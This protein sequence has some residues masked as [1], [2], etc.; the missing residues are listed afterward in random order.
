ML[1]RIADLINRAPWRVSIAAVLFAAVAGA[2]GG[3]VAATLK[4]GGFVDPSSE[5]SRAAAQIERATGLRADGGL[6]AVVDTGQPV[7]SA[8]TRAEVERVAGVIGRERAVSR[9]LTYYGSG[10][11]A[12]VSANGRETLVAGLF[13]SQSDEDATAAAK[14]VQAALAPDGQVRVGGFAVANAQ[15][16]D[17]VTQDLARAEVLAFPIL[18]LLSLWVFRGAVAALLP[19]MVGGTTIV[20]AFLGL[21]AVSTFMPLSIYALNLI[22]GLGLGLAID[23]SLFMISRYREE[24]AAGAPPP[25]AIRRTLL[26]AGRTILFSSLMVAAAMASLLLFPLR[27]LYSMGVGGILVALIAAT[28]A[29]LV[30]PAALLLLGHRVNALAPRR[31]QRS[32]QGAAGGGWYR[33]ARGV[34]R[35]PV[36]VAAAAALA[37]VLLGLPFTGIRFTSIDAS[38]LPAGA[39]ARQVA[40]VVGRDFPASTSSVYLVVQAPGSAASDV[41]DLANGVAALPD[42]AGVGAPQPA[43]AEHWRLDVQTRGGDLSSASQDAVRE[44]RGLRSRHPIL[45]GGSTAAFVDLQASLAQHLPPAIALVALTTLVL[46]FLMTGS[47]VLP[48]KALVMNLLTLSAAFG[49]LVLVFQQGRFQDLLRY[50]S[51]GA[52]ESTQPVL[53]FALVFGLSTDYGVFLLSR[54]KELHDG[55][56]SNAE[57]VAG[58]VGRTG[59]IVTAAALLFC[60]AIGAFA[61]SQIVFIKE[62][63]VGT[64]AGVL[65]DAT[66]VRALLVPAL[67]AMLG[68]WNWWAP[69]PLRWLHSRVGPIEAGPAPVAAAQP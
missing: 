19:L 10:S 40:E 45:V 12:L 20:G 69:R 3:P 36:P 35:R 64:A 33:L 11:P 25:V 6:L 29:L 55:G 37:L 44:I 21:R 63:G 67:M 62:L 27:F 16:N 51:Q 47:L 2:L 26:T 24:L 34:M 1:D 5:S 8:A 28:V 46:L 14:R 54:I 39:S 53:L 17:R 50:T 49:V 59:R 22:T 4:G 52:L 18:F 31:W 43:G 32:L 58:G 38:V 7:A 9:T 23:Y 66:I 57:A 13:A 42:V 68:R 41:A 30:L 56:A 15:V 65:L 60:V 48:V 61:T